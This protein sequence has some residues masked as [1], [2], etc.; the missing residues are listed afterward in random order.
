MKTL[1]FT[2]ILLM[3]TLFIKA[4]AQEIPGGSILM[5]GSLGF[6]TS[7]ARTEQNG[8]EI[9]TGN[10]Y[11]FDL[12]PKMGYFFFRNFAAGLTIDFSTSGSSVNTNFDTL[13]TKEKITTNQTQLLAGPFFR[14]YFFPADRIAFFGELSLGFGVGSVSK[15]QG[16]QVGPGATSASSTAQIQIGIGP[17]LTFFANDIVALEALVKYNMLNSTSSV[18]TGGTTI[19]NSTT[20]NSINFG[21]G[22]Q[23]Y[24]NRVIG[25]VQ[26]REPG[27]VY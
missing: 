2:L 27:S 23:F 19:D 6:S 9:E 20:I 15:D 4:Q 11:Q 17:G 14:Y 21:L 16:T 8:K 10:Q 24:F 18:T 26:T 13:S 5:G 7:S 3:S 25:G 22:F 12:S 1:K